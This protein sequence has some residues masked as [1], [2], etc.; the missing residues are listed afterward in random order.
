MLLNETEKTTLKPA[1][2]MCE[3]YEKQYAKNI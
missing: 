1:P 3:K 2:N